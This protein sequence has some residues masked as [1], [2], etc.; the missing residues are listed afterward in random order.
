MD[1]RALSSFTDYFV[2]CSGNS[3]PQ[4]RAMVNELK[5][6]L[7]EEHHIKPLAVDGFPESHWVVA[8]FAG[9]VVHIFHESKRGYYSLED[10]WKD[11]PRVLMTEAAEA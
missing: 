7:W 8:D 3:E 9:V 5:D 10:L 6:R 4:L 1:V 2:I 11:A